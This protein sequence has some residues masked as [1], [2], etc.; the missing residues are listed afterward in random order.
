VIGFRLFFACALMCA[1]WIA[2]PDD[3]E[4][5]NQEHPKGN[6]PHNRR[7]FVGPGCLAYSVL[8]HHRI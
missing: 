1:E 5:Q 7:P 6:F 2:T 3:N 8:E 4:H